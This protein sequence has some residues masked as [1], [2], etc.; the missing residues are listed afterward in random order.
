VNAG[1][2]LPSPDEKA[3]NQRLRE[4][5]LAHL[6]AEPDWAPVGMRRLPKGLVRLH[7]RLAPRLPMTH[8]L[9]WAEGTTRADELER[10]RIATL[11]AE[12][13]EAARNRHERAVYFRVLRT[14]K[15]PGW[16]DWEPEQDGKP[17]T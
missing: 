17:G 16:A 8:P 4:A 9:G 14:R 1:G 12:E 13:Q 5:H 15:P 11:P 10:E 6:A 2:L 7:N 3:L